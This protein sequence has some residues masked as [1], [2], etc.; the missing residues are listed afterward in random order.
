MSYPSYGIPAPYPGYTGYSMYPYQ[1]VMQ[2]QV[3]AQ[4]QQ[5]EQVQQPLKKSNCEFIH[6][7][8]LQQVKDHIVQPNQTL[9]FLDNNRPVLYRKIVDNFG[10]GKI[11]AY[12]LTNVDVSQLDAPEASPSR[13][14]DKEVYEALAARISRLE[15]S[16]FRQEG[17]HEPV[18]PEQPVKPAY[19]GDQK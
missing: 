10:T 14:P 13:T 18:N 5:P 3:P 12:N 15:Q 4:A 17:S 2:P 16:I 8:G 19:R 1:Q 9:Y 6:V 11:E 7:N